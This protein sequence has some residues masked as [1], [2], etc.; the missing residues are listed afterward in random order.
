M[1]LLVFDIETIPQQG[2]LTTTQQ[3]NLDKKLAKAFG[4]ETPTNEEYN[5]KRSFIMGTNPH[6]GEIVCI[7][8]KKVLSTGEFDAT[9]LVGTEPEILTKFWDIAKKH[10]GRYVH[11]NGLGFDVPWI[12]KRSMYH[13]IKP[14]N[15]EFLDTRRYTK[16]PHFDVQ[17]ILA[18]WDRYAA[19]TLDLACDFLKVPSPKEG[20]VKGDQVEQAFL[21][22]KINQIA[23]YCL[24]DVDAT[25]KV[26]NIVQT[27]TKF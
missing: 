10:R 18:D 24:R 8:V 27:Y 9:S 14:S 6:F 2:K 3:E 4:N 7:G 11:Y 1:D 12:I 19:V 13:G 15:K 20:E 5:K 23:E 25:H 21:D 22:G 16:Y 26:Y 17:M